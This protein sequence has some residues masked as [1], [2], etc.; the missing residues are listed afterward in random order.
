MTFKL[1]KEE[2]F[3]SKKITVSIFEHEKTKARHIHSAYE[4]EENS[5]SVAFR[6]L[7][8]NSKGIPHILEHS[9]LCGSKKFPSKNLFFNMR[10]RNFDTFMNASTGF[11]TTQY[12]FSSIDKNGFFNLM[13]VYTD[14]VFFPT[15]EKE[16]F[17]QEGWRYEVKTEGNQ[18]QLVYSGVVYNEM[19][20]A[21]SNPGRVSFVE[22]LKAVY[23][24]SQ[25][26]NFSGGHPIDITNLTYK[27]FVD[28]HKKYYH[29]SNATF[30][31]FGSI[32]YSEIHEKLEDWVLSKFDYLEIDKTINMNHHDVKHFIGEHPG[33]QGVTLNLGWKLNNFKTFEDY[34]ETHLICKLLSGGKNNVDNK[35]IS[36]GSSNGFEILPIHQPAIFL[37]V[38]TEQE[39]LLNIKKTVNEF[40]EN[41]VNNGISS[42]EFD[43]IFDM[44]EMSQRK[45]GDEGFGRNLN[46]IYI[47]LDKFGIKD[48]ENF[49]N[50]ELYKTI[51]QKLSNSQYFKDK[52]KQIFIENE[53]TFEYLSVANP[54]FSQSL[55][56]QL[57]EKVY[58][59]SLNM[60]NSDFLEIDKMNQDLINRRNQPDDLSKLPKITLEEVE[61]PKEKIKLLHNEDIDGV[62]VYSYPKD[63]NGLIR[64]EVLFPV[65]VK[66]KEDFLNQYLMMELIGDL[67]FKE[68]SLEESNFYRES[69]TSDIMASFEAYE[70]KLYWKFTLLSLSEN[71]EH[72]I[73]KVKKYF[74]DI[75][76]DDVNSI[77]MQI[78]SYI[79]DFL[80][81]YQENAHY[82]AL[83]DTRGKIS[84]KYVYE[85]LVNLNYY[86]ELLTE[87]DRK[88]P[89]ELIYLKEIYENFFKNESEI[90]II[91]SKE[92]IDQLKNK[93]HVFN[94]KKSHHQVFVDNTKK[95]HVLFDF[96]IPTNHVAVSYKVND[97]HEEFGPE[98]KVFEGL[99][100]DYLIKNIRQK[101]GAYGAN[102]DYNN[103]GILTFYS[104][105]DSQIQ[106]TIDLITELP[107]AIDEIGLTEEMLEISK[108]NII[109]TL[110]TPR[111]NVNQAVLEFNREMK[112]KYIPH[113]KLSKLV[114]NVNLDGVKKAVKTL[115]NPQIAV[116][117]SEE[118]YIDLDNWK[119]EKPL[120]S[121]KKNIEVKNKM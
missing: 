89:S 30:Y 61:L 79:R 99:I 120:H 36:F 92:D 82:Y 27:E 107:N 77:K 83:F 12:P 116:S 43:N 72:I 60:T 31:T 109:K 24:G 78:S 57:E 66:S 11:E 37:S 86:T 108:L 91:A 52:L 80:S 1:I 9:V 63:N 6:T 81:N 13:E 48:V 32:P 96:N 54:L 28:F 51:R 93:V 119:L 34:Y 40:L 71:K 8:E 38:E 14:V 75:N 90:F 45:E 19:I 62:K 94:G 74:T 121:F 20:G 68:M 114:M 29:P 118:N 105:R 117:S 87:L 59:E 97:I 103:S 7:P 3:P 22:M 26:E 73:N 102:A 17:L 84:N 47:T 88:Q 15:L 112:G 53:K 23:K 101:N 21:Y 50:V 69:K 42:Q 95:E 56:N 55:K 58:Q 16:T 39:N 106:K 100:K 98:F 115:V 104:Y 35:L 4:T 44:I 70:D 64:F 46:N 5:F 65:N 113:D 25:Y 111:S 76:F 110:K 33:E 67:P 10:G 85:Q 2:Y 41:V 49:N 18:K